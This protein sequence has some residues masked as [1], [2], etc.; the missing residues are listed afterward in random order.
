MRYWILIGWIGIVCSSELEARDSLYF[1]SPVQHEI[2]LAGSFGEL[3]SS[4]FHAGVDIKPKNKVVGDTLMA[5]AAGY[6]SRIKI[7]TGGYGR[8]LYIDHPNGYTTVYAHLLSFP[9]TLQSYI[10]SMQRKAQSYSV[11]LYPDSARFEFEQGE[12]VGLMG[13]SGRSYAPHLHFEIRETKSEIP[14]DPAFWGISASDSKAPTLQSYS[15]EGLTPD[16]RRTWQKIYYPT[17]IEDQ[18]THIIPAWRVGVNVQGY[19]QMNG[20]SNHNGIYH[21]QLF[22]DGVLHWESKTDAVDWEE[23]KYINAYIDYHD[24]KELNRTA[25]CGYVLPANPLSIYNR[26]LKNTPI[27]LYKDSARNVEVVLRDMSGN[28]RRVQFRLLRAA[29]IPA[30]SFDDYNVKLEW[31]SSYQISMGSSLFNIPAGTFAKDTYFQYQ[32]ERN[33][34]GTKYHIHNRTTRIFG[35]IRSKMPIAGLDSSKHNKYCLVYKDEK[36]PTSFGGRII[37]DSLESKLYRLGNFGVELD[38]IAP[39][40][41]AIDFSISAAVKS[42]FEFRVDDNYACM[43]E[44]DDV[45]INVWIDGIWQITPYK[46]MTRRLTIPLEHLNVGQHELHIQVRDDRGN[47]SNWTSAFEI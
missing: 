4:H 15:I 42:A 38:T 25:V 31:D 35:A 47:I 22:V 46:I 36:R 40:I 14:E 20:S 21:R 9:D 26:S 37:G 27:K 18:G 33:Q 41:E 29:D 11:D 45:Q 28:E 8:A 19:D 3:R 24:K 2:V 23:T 39:Y 30:P 12:F 13:N 17:N 16:F 7:Q 32:E 5:A 1:I 44:A 43:G 34:E 6:V 10:E